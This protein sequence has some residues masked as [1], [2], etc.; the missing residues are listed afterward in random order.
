[1]DWRGRGLIDCVRYLNLINVRGRDEVGGVGCT[2][3]FTLG[4]CGAAMGFCLSDSD[5][6]AGDQPEDPV[7]GDRQSDKY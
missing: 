7:L 5:R 2:I 1:M 6:Q 4:L 3:I